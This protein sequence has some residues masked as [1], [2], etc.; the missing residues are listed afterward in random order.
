MAFLHSPDEN[1]P[2]YKPSIAMSERIILHIDMDA[3]FASVEQQS[4]PVLRGKPIAVIG[5]GKRTVI[6]T[7]S[8]EARA[9][10]VKTGMNIFEGRTICPELILV[11]GN[12]RKYTDTSR[13]VVEILRDYTPLVEVYSIDEAFLDLTGTVRLLGPPEGIARRIKERIEKRFGITCSV[14]IAPNKLLSKLAAGLKKPDGLVRV[15][16]EEVSSL[17]EQLPVM[18]LC[19]I[20]RRLGEHLAALDIRTCGQLGRF[21]VANLRQRFGIVGETLSAMGQGIDP[22]PVV[23]LGEEPE[24]KSIGHSTTL[25]RDISDKERIHQTLLR[26]SEMVARR[27]R[28]NHLCGRTVTLTLRYAD[29]TTFSKRMRLDDFLHHGPEIYLTVR[30]ILSALRL[31]QAVRLLG[32]TLSDLARDYLQLS[33]FEEERKREEI[34]RAMDAV[35]DRYG[36]FT[37]TWGTLLKRSKEPGVISPA[38]RPAGS[39]YVN[40][41]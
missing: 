2:C 37:V 20:G 35:N 16:P 39:H 10:G 26:L 25:P 23:P 14:G 30:E 21:P 27:A 3:F 22:S 34:A 12:N 41:R 4:R 31:R 28:R 38:W 24:P 6:T 18:E 15:R 17:M 19:G 7:S 29:F 33:L 36:M 11:V 40:V 32:V 8:Y 5:S 9:R 13:G 1:S